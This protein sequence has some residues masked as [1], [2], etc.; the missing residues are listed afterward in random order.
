MSD[1]TPRGSSGEY[2]MAALA[3]LIGAA[4]LY[5]ARSVW[6]PLVLL[7]AAAVLLWPHRDSQFVSRVLLV[8][9]IV[10]FLWAFNTVSD[11][12]VPLFI[13]LALAYI[14]APLARWLSAATR[15]WG[16]LRLRGSAVALV[17]CL[18]ILALIGFVGAETGS[19][20]IRQSDELAQ[21]VEDA[22]I[23]IREDLPSLSRENSLTGALVQGAVDALEQITQRIPELSRTLLSSVG[24]VL[25]GALGVL[26]TL[27]FFFYL[28][29]DY[30]T[31]RQGFRERY[32]PESINGFID[33]RMSRVNG[34]LRS[35]LK[36]Y[37]TTSTIV[38]VL[39]LGLLLAFGIEIAFLLALLA[40]LLN[41]VPI[42]GF[43]VTAVLIL[44]V[45]L[46]TGND[47]TTL[48]LLFAGL[49]TI[50]VLEGNFLAPRIVGRKVG[51][52]PVAVI[53]SIGIFGRIL[54]VAG[55]LLGIPL[56]A[57]LSREWED[58]LRRRKERSVPDV[59]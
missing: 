23:Y 29:K 38:F 27:L 14:F 59:N 8:M 39:T 32:L 54:G 26:V 50:N 34:I 9:A 1:R 13:A 19:L 43:W 25:T 12:L 10:G 31:L 35:F 44:L 42:L 15:R 57:I 24:G 48:L 3:V 37:L 21:L 40:G 56:A 49:A 16:F 58:F 4:F 11:L 28:M 46:A 53:L 5:S 6:H 47:W 17:L 22:E 45:A 30:S 55:V 51:L 18:L 20:L 2:V 36:G 33:N 52:H 41:I 7:A